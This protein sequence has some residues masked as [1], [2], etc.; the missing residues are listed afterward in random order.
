[1][2]HETLHL[3]EHFP[4]LA[5]ISRDPALTAYV[6][7][8]QAEMGWDDVK[9]PAVI[10]CP[11]GGYTW[12]ST[13]EDEPIALKLLSWGYRVFT[14][15]YS[16]KPSRFPT[17]LCEVAAAIEL[18]RKNAEHWHV[19]PDR[20][21]L[22]GFSAGG[23][24]T[25]H[26]ANCYD[27]PEVRKF[28]P[29]SKPVAASVMCYPVV[30]TNSALRNNESFSNLAGGQNFSDAEIAQFSLEHLVTDRTP[31]TFLWH[32]AEDDIV[33]VANSLLYAQALAQ[34]NVPFS[35]HIYPFGQH[36]LSTA[37]SLSCH[38]LDEKSMLA[39]DWLDALKKWLDVT[40]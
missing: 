25:G 10:V 3:K 28:I 34:H 2:L 27:I 38:P 37:D 31:P 16:C 5:S 21:A 7:Y 24:L 30:T 19:D 18:I 36:G 40:L 6:P 32:T 15:H 23:H 11:G 8:N 12:V 9:Y 4:A 29:E 17:Q 22:M 13:R 1:M 33:P 35:L 20:I 14:L 39:S 26:Y